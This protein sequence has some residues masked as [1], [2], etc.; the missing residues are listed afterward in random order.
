MVII[1]TISVVVSLA[2]YADLIDRSDII[3]K[4]KTDPL[5]C[6]TDKDCAQYYKTECSCPKPVNVF[7]RDKLT[8]KPEKK[9]VNNTGGNICLI[10][11]PPVSKACI[12]FKCQLIGSTN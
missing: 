4:Y 2:F 6:L 10:Y 5:F 7:N 3:F 8:Y 1:I 9:N 12:N 11:C